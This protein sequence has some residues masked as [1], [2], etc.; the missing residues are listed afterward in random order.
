MKKKFIPKFP[1]VN[2]T[3]NIYLDQNKF[4]KQVFASSKKSTKLRLGK[5]LR[6]NKNKRQPKRKEYNVIDLT[7][8]H[9]EGNSLDSYSDLNLTNGEGSLPPLEKN[10]PLSSD[11]REE[12]KRQER[13]SRSLERGTNYNNTSKRHKKNNDSNNSIAVSDNSITL[14]GGIQINMSSNILTMNNKFNFDQK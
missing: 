13:I 12:N 3:K 10:S 11:F 1:D 8:N 4:K 14:A 6:N 7:L 2:A 9:H 5:N